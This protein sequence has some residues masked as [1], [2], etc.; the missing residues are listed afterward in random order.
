MEIAWFKN[1]IVAGLSYSLEICSAL[2]I[3]ESLALS[4]FQLDG[5]SHHPSPVAMAGDCVVGDAIRA[6]AMLTC[7]GMAWIEVYTGNQAFDPQLQG[8]PCS[9]RFL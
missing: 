3:S 5:G 8:F 4:C 1:L 7:L 9:V 6:W 2:A